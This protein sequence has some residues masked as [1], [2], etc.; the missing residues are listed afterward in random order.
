VPV[1]AAVAAVVVAAEQFALVAEPEAAVRAAE[2][3]LSTQ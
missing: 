1:A 3:S 2:P